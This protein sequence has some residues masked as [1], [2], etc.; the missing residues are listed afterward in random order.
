MT[1]YFNGTY[2]SN[3][4]RYHAIPKN[5]NSTNIGLLRDAESLYVSLY[6]WIKKGKSLSIIPEGHRD[7]MKDLDFKNFMKYI[8][9]IK[10]GYVNNAHWWG[11]SM[12]FRNTVS[13][14]IGPYT[15]I[16]CLMYCNNDFMMMLKDKNHIDYM[17]PQSNIDEYMIKYFDQMGFNTSEFENSIEPHLNKGNYEETLIDEETS[18]L[19]KHKE[20]FIYNQLSIISM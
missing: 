3:L 8:Y 1:K 19:I 13:Y 5:Y 7:N 9:S 2:Q 6:N 17:I 10:Y 12:D 20:R 4:Y 18:K 14:D 11:K 15:L 16:Y